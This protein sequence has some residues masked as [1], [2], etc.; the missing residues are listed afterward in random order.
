M[1]LLFD[2]NISHKVLKYLTQDFSSST[3]IKKENLLNA[4]DRTIFMFAKKNDFIIVTQDSDFNELIS[5][6]GFPPKVIWFRVGNLTTESIANLL[7]TNYNKL[8]AFNSS[9]TLGIFQF[10]K[11]I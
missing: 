11:P 9:N 7:N 6:L 5:V 3:T 2:Q 4:N 8:D 10:I 1:K